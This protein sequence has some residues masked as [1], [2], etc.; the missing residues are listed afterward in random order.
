MTA[1]RRIVGS[2]SIKPT[3]RQQIRNHAERLAYLGDASKIR[4]FLIREYGDPSRVPP[5]AYLEDIVARRRAQRSEPI[6]GA[7]RRRR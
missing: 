3:P 5:H 6:T 4:A 2:V 7:V 1:P